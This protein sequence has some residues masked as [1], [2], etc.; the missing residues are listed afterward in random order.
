M[1]SVLKAACFRRPNVLVH[2][3]RTLTALAAAASLVASQRLLAQ[4]PLLQPASAPVL[5]VTP[6]LVSNAE[7]L[8]LSLSRFNALTGIQNDVVVGTGSSGPYTLSWRNARQNS[9]TVLL[10]ERILQRNLDY[11]ID[12]GSGSLSFATPLTAGQ[13]ARV[14]YAADTTTA[15]LNRPSV[16]I[17]VGWDIWQSGSDHVRLR[18]L[19]RMDKSSMT[20][21]AQTQDARI[22]GQNALQW[23]GSHRAGTGKTASSILNSKFYADLQGGDWLARGGLALENQTRL[24]IANLG[25]TYIH[26]GALFTQSEESGIPVGQEIVEA[27]GALMPRAGVTVNARVRQSTQLLDTTPHS[28]GTPAARS[29]GDTTQEAGAS[30]AVA[31]PGK[32]GGK[33]SASVED[34]Y[35]KEGAYRKRQALL[36]APTLPIASTQISGGVQETSAPG[37]QRLVGL[38]NGSAKPFRYVEVAGDVRVRTSL[39][40]ETT[41]DPNA[42]NTYGLKMNLTP[43]KRLR[44]SGSVLRNPEEGDGSVRR[45]QRHAVGLESDWGVF[46]LRGQFGLDS[47]YETAK[48]T[49]SAEIGLDLH[50]TRF[51]TFTTGFRGASLF[52]KSASGENTYLLGFTHRL[53]SVFDLSLSGSMTQPASGDASKP[54][55]RTEAKIGLRF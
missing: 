25:L 34:R 16:N 22:P 43:S 23:T 31:L 50:L 35:Q 48:L 15:V 19:Y 26:G 41:P 4:A 9:E 10:G 55:L 20:Q 32:R 6:A 12:L 18:S 51:D 29:V 49:N 14:T 46:A 44:L 38:L 1:T 40:S 21:D 8:S 36:D 17:P 28:A 24:G 47:E 53:G 2:C 52:D 37:Q 42:R 13:M 7:G 33:V 54:H 30:V 39:L 45:V 3:A 5:H 27:T 11:A